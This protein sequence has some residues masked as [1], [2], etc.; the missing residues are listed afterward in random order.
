MALTYNTIFSRLGRLFAHAAAIRTFQGTLETEYTS[1]VA[2]YSG[3]DMNMIGRLSQ[4]LDGRISS[5]ANTV[6]DLEAATVKTLIDSTD[7]NFTLEDL[8]I[9]GAL[10]ELIRQ[11]LA[12]SETVQ[13]SE[14]TAGTVTAGSSNVGNGT[15]VV[16]TQSHAIDEF[17]N[18]TDNRYAQNM[19]SETLQVIC[20]NDSSQ[21]LIDAGHEHFSVRG[22]RKLPISDKDWPGGSGANSM[23]SA[24]SSRSNGGQGPGQNICTNSNFEDF[25]TNTPKHWTIDTGS[26]GTHVVKVTSGQYEGSACV[27]FVGDGSTTPKISQTLNSTLGS[28]G[29]LNPDQPYTI[30]FAAKYATLAPG[31]T[32]NVEVTKSDGTTIYNAADVHRE[33]SNNVASA[34]LSTSWQLFTATGFMP[35]DLDKG[36]KVVVTFSGNIANTSEVFIDNLCVAQ[37][38]ALGK[39]IGHVQVIPGSTAFRQ[40]DTFTVAITNDGAGEFCQEFDRFFDMSAR[41]LSLPTA[42][43]SLGGTVTINDSLIA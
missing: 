26:A 39:N 21:A 13:A 32:I 4:S 34:S 28:R 40:G 25:D 31:V 15:L 33:M 14:V 30:T 12:D 19:H 37:M 29:Y 23:I 2:Q 16:S 9:T 6:Q 11:M 43:P 18:R 36:S 35:A 24:V 42:L 17:G 8:T 27:K 22:Q 5:A 41:G 20:R 38:R 3:S 10:R 7:A 1:T